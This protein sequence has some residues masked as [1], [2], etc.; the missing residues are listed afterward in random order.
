M[1][2]KL[3]LNRKPSAFFLYCQKTNLNYMI[4]PFAVIKFLLDLNLQLR[5]K[6]RQR[7]LVS[8]SENFKNKHVVTAPSLLRCYSTLF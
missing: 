4:L 5:K 3:H 1:K 6:E 7:A 2:S 8:C